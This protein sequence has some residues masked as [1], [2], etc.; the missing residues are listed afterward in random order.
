MAFLGYI[1]SGVELVSG[2]FCRNHKP[3]RIVEFRQTSE[4]VVYYRDTPRGEIKEYEEDD[5]VRL[6]DGN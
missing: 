3:G 6:S 1:E 4:G 2:H 5:N